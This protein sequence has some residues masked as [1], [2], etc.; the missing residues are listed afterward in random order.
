MSL[1]KSLHCT[2]Q[3]L[4]PSSIQPYCA[5]SK[6]YFK[7]QCTCFN[8]IPWKFLPLP[9]PHPNQCCVFNTRTMT[10]E[11]QMLNMIQH[12]IGGGGELRLGIGC[13]LEASLPILLKVTVWTHTV[14]SLLYSIKKNHGMGWVRFTFNYLFKKKSQ[15]GN[16]E[17]L[18]KLKVTG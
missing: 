15:Y 12:W 6:V 9:S 11:N 4:I 18:G 2:L 5:I 10:R 14:L 3:M 17:H 7:K 8:Q 16:S 1:R 13:I